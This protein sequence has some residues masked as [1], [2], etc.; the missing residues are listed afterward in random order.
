MHS[1]EEFWLL[2]DMWAYL[3]E[4]FQNKKRASRSIAKTGFFRSHLDCTG[5]L[6]I[7]FLSKIGFRTL[8]RNLDPFRVPFWMLFWSLFGSL[9]DPLG[10]PWA[11]FG[12]PLARLGAPWHLWE[13]R[14]RT[15][16]LD[17][18]VLITLTCSW[19]LFQ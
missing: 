14:R 6:Q 9:W 16:V 3:L 5:M 15:W 2:W 8:D 7:T 10:R 13:L 12:F 19:V 11:P 17:L 1:C 4:S 18:M